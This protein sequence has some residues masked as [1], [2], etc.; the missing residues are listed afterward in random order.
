MISVRDSTITA[1]YSNCATV[2]NSN[3]LYFENTI[4]QATGPWEVYSSNTTGNYQGAYIKNIYSEASLSDNNF[5]VI[6]GSVASGI[7]QIYEQVIQGTTGASAYIENVPTGTEVM[8]LTAVTGTPDATHDWVG[9]TSTAHYT[10]TKVPA[11]QSPFP[12][13]VT[14]DLLQV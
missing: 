2:Y 12:A 1:N 9:Q 4:C 11:A 10:P 8:Y 5:A 13:L 7:F 6:T 3:G 14:L